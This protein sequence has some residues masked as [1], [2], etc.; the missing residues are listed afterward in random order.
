MIG[1]GCPG[2]VRLVAGV[3]GGRCRRVAIVRVTLRAGHGGVRTRQRIVRVERVIELGIEPV[4]RRVAICASV[5][6]AELHV[7]RIVAACKVGRVARKAVRRRANEYIIAMTRSAWQCGMH[8]GERVAGIFQMIELRAE[9]GIHGV[10]ALARSRECQRDV[11][12]D[13]R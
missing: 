9:P 12:D 5:R 13:G 6:Q 11:I 3:A 10:T 2:K 4:G 8:P 7:R 1:I